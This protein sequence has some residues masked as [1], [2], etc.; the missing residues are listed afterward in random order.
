VATVTLRPNADG[1]Y[2]QWLIYPTTPTTHY[3]KVDEETPNNGTDY[4]DSGFADGLVHDVYDTFKKPPSGIPAG[5]K[6]NSVT[7]YSNGRVVPTQAGLKV[8]WT[9]V[10]LV[11]GTLYKGAPHNYTTWTTTSTTWTTNPATG[12]AWTLSDIEALEFGVF[13]QDSYD[14]V[15]DE[16]YANVTAVWLVIDYTPP[17]P[18]GKFAFLKTPVSMIYIG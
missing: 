3:D 4:L 10:L 2:K 12:A 7:V 16:S 11:G 1:T 18:A 13:G 6:I 8:A 5:S 17:P 14:P 9:E 15:G